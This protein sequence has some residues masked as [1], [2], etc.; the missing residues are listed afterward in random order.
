MEDEAKNQMIVK[1]AVIF[2]DVM[3][4]ITDL[5]GKADSYFTGLN[6]QMIA[7]LAILVMAT[8]PILRRRQ[9]TPTDL[10]AIINN[11]NLLTEYVDKLEELDQSTKQYAFIIQYIREDL[12]G[13]GTVS[14]THLTL[15]T[16]LG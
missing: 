4:A 8:V 16:I 5:K 7:N 10:Q 14:Y 2:S 11:F 15:P 1:R 6:R 9:A 13:K 12:L 3:Q